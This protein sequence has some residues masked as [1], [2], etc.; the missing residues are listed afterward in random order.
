MSHQ[1]ETQAARS[2]FWTYFFLSGN[3]FR[4]IVSVFYKKY[5]F[6]LLKGQYKASKLQND[7][8]CDSL[9]AIIAK[10]G[11]PINV[12]TILYQTFLRCL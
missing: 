4:Q 3:C 11:F 2:I 5:I 6:Y 8:C 12:L 10:Y 1:D 7:R 9:L